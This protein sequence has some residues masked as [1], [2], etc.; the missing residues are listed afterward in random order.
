VGTTGVDRIRHLE[1]AHAIRQAGTVIALAAGGAVAGALLAA[2]A[3]PFEA[4]APIVIIAVPLAPLVAAALWTRPHLA[5]VLVAA[6]FPLGFAS[7]PIGV[8][9]LQAVDVAVLVAASVVVLHRLNEWK[10]PLVWTPHLW[11]LFAIVCWALFALLSAADR[12]SAVK[13]SGTLISAMVLT[14]LVITVSRKV[15][16]VRLIAGSLVVV[17]T[18]ICAL[19][20][21]SIEDLRSFY[22]GAVVE[23]RAAGL[24]ADPNELGSF[25]SM[26]M[27]ASLGIALGTRRVIGR[28]GATVATATL[29]AA[30]VLSLSRGA[31][32]GAAAGFVVLLVTIGSARRVLFLVSIPI[33]VA[34]AGYAIAN[35]SSPAIQIV[36]ERSRTLTDFDQPYDKRS[37]VWVEALQLIGDDPLTGQGPGNFA[38]AS[39]KS[40]SSGGFVY[41]SHAHNLV[42]NVAAEIGIPGALLLVGL[43]VAVAVA[44]RLVLRWA[45]ASGRITDLALAAGISAALVA[46]LVQGLT[47]YFLG[48]PIIDATT[49]ILVGAILALWKILA[50]GRASPEPERALAIPA[51]P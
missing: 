29:A 37:D 10:P 19:A 47:N 23:G 36:V 11:W 14:S 4:L 34:A 45:R 46:S 24:F 22:G 48:N 31:W 15:A 50:A 26:M 20:V 33:V 8:L 5:P 12:A 21:I 1:P 41:L 16:D 25:S 17:G 27:L 43:I 3:V 2:A 42:L 38:D 51:Q 28:I 30:L 18:A 35:P 32:L 49:W 9:S 44:A 13:A 7:I 40:A 39:R 6:S